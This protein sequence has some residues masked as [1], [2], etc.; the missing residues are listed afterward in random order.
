M[1]VNFDCQ[2]APFVLWDSDFYALGRNKHL[3]GQENGLLD[4]HAVL[5]LQVNDPYFSFLKLISIEHPQYR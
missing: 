5:P 2:D 4:F 3:E 1:V